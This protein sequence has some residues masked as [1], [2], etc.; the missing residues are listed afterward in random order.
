MGRVR[1]ARDGDLGQEIFTTPQLAARLAGGFCRPADEEVL[2]P[3]ISH[4]LGEGNLYE[5]GSVAE[6]P[7]MVRAVSQSC[8]RLA[9]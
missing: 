2:Y 9:G 4:A 5:L 7:G 6:M 1:A 8:T 3:A